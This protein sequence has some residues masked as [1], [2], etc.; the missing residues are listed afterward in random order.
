MAGTPFPARPFTSLIEHK[1]LRTW[2]HLA[3]TDGFTIF[4]L[5]KDK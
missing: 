5:R 2:P 4:R 1:M 3:A